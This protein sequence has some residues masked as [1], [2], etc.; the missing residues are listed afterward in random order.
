MFFDSDT[1]YPVS[2]SFLCLLRFLECSATPTLCDVT[3]VTELTPRL[4]SDK[5]LSQVSKMI[6][7]QS[8]FFSSHFKI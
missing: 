5:T 1:S 8:H 4:V 2:P 3:E 6:R 7:Q